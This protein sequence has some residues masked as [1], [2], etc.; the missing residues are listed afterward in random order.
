[1]KDS[2]V[3]KDAIVQSSTESVKQAVSSDSNAIGYVSLAHMSDD[4]KGIS[5]E[6]VEASTD[7]ILNGDYELQRPF[8]IIFN[9]V[10]CSIN[11]THF[12]NLI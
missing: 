5:V 7:T 2:E 3:K 6:G 10:I 1:M 11:I 8:I 9:N 4:I 12:S